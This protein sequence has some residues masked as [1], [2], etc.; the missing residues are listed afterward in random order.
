VCIYEYW[1]HIPFNGEL[2]LG[3]YS[4]VNLAFRGKWKFAVLVSVFHLKFLLGHTQQRVS[5]TNVCVNL[6][7]DVRVNVSCAQLWAAGTEL[8][9]PLSVCAAGTHWQG[10]HREGCGLQAWG[11]QQGTEPCTGTSSAGGWMGTNHCGS[12]A[13]SHCEC[14]HCRGPQL[15]CASL[16]TGTEL[17][18]ANTLSC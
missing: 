17:T 18:P 13:L 10:T 12:S 15:S 11:V 5:I 1:R 8:C 4:G 3:N 2:F 6:S 7:S 14:H 16:H 9:S